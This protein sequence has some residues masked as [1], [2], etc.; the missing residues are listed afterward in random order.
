MCLL[1]LVEHHALLQ[2][3]NR[4]QAC[5]GKTQKN[6][7]KVF[8][9]RARLLAVSGTCPNDPKVVATLENCGDGE[10]FTL[11]LE[12]QGHVL[13]AARSAC[14]NYVLQKIIQVL[15]PQACQFIIDEIMKTP[16]DV[17]ILARHQYGCR[18]LQRLL[19]HC[20]AQQMEGLVKLL[21]EDATA[22]VRHNY[23]TFVMQQIFDFGT[24]VQRQ[25]LGECLFS[26]LGAMGN[27]E[28]ATQVL[29]KALIH[30]PQ[31]VALAR[32]LV[33]QLAQIARGRHSHHTVLAAVQLLSPEDLKRASA[34][35]S[36]KVQKLWASRYGRLVVKAIP[37]LH[38]KCMGM[39][40]REAAAA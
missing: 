28:N 1:P 5:R 22:L 15:R 26:T 37:S 10:R 24:E 35:L 18:I 16:A 14:A 2:S 9:W 21:L 11:A 39:T 32:A 7:S 34:L 27:D 6:Q 29:Q 4:K 8:A 38:D 30:A 17:P 40:K 19:E 23:G 33:P 36:Q 12:L 3:Q 25:Q 13:A 31:K 20:Q